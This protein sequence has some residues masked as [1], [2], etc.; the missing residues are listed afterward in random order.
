MPAIPLQAPEGLNV[1]AILRNIA[2]CYPDLN[3]EKT[4]FI[5]AFAALYN[6]L[7]TELDKYL[8]HPLAAETADRIR[9]RSSNIVRFARETDLKLRLLGVLNRIT[10]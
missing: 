2:R 6:N 3:E 10:N 1:N 4:K 8:G 9:L 7:I 5:D